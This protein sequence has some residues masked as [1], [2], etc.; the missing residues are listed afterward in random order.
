[1]KALLLSVVLLIVSILSADDLKPSFD[2]RLRTVEA[3]EYTFSFHILKSGMIKHEDVEFTHEQFA[4]LAR[5]IFRARP[6]ARMSFLADK[7][8]SFSIHEPPMKTAADI[9]FEDIIG[10]GASF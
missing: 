6:S 4:A 9:G 3:N 1:M 2:K 5:S 8:V 10:F 7:G